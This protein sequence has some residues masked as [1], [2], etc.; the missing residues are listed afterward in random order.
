MP[1]RSYSSAPAGD[2]SDPEALST[3]GLTFELDGHLFECHGVF[4]ATDFA[5]LAAPLLDASAGWL[6]PDAVAAVGTFYRTIMGADTYRAFAAHR[7][8]HRTPAS[9]IAQIMTDLIEDL[10]AR[11]PQRPSPSPGGP[12]GTGPSSAGGSPPPASGAPPARPGGRRHRREQ[13]DP[14]GVLP[15]DWAGS[16]DIVTA[17]PPPPR[18]D[19]EGQEEEEEMAGTRRTVNLGDPARTRIEPLYPQLRGG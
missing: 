16:G 11:D 15:P 1:P 5:D 9:V 8:K 14:Q 6:E 13:V 19:E 12:P 7:R 3:E 2:G 18:Q 10:V 4:D 17:P